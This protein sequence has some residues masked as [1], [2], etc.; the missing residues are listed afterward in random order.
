MGDSVAPDPDS[1]LTGGVRRTSSTYHHYFC[2]WNW[3]PDRMRFSK[4]HWQCPD[5]VWHE[6][7][8]LLKKN[9][10]ASAKSTTAMWYC[11]GPVRSSRPF[12]FPAILSPGPLPL[13]RSRFVPRL[14]P[15]WRQNC[16]NVKLM[17]SGPSP[18]PSLP[19][20]RRKG[21]PMVSF[22]CNIVE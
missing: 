18:P 5:G 7:I 19:G 15:S 21:L 1:E 11:R 9:S 12:K 3:E 16:S 10:A 2:L 20:R 13:A 22:P 17:S 8:L 6:Y 14:Y 4:M